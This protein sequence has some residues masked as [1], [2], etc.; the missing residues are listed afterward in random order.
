MQQRLF[1]FALHPFKAGWRT[2]TNMMYGFL[3]CTMLH[4]QCA[5]QDILWTKNMKKEKTAM[6]NPAP[7]LIMKKADIFSPSSSELHLKCSNLTPT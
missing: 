2:K 7:L 1:C 4:Y 5:L 3:Q 6:I